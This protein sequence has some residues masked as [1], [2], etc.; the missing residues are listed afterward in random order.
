MAQLDDKYKTSKKNTCIAT[1]KHIWRE[2][3]LL[4]RSQEC[5]ESKFRVSLERSLNAYHA[6][7]GNENVGNLI[8]DQAWEGI[9][10]L[11]GVL[12]EEM[13]DISKMT[14]G[15]NNADI[16]HK[17]H[18]ELKDM[19]S[20]FLNESQESAFR[21][22]QSISELTK[23]NIEINIELLA[24]PWIRISESEI[25]N[26]KDLRFVDDELQEHHE[27]EIETLLAGHKDRKQQLNQ[28]YQDI[29]Q[30]PFGGWSDIDH[31][32]FR[33]LHD[34]YIGNEKHLLYRLRLEL[35]HHN[36]LSLSVCSS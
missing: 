36:S 22:Q 16:I 34:E 28:Q 7:S 20:N 15:G 5:Q 19:H 13:T 6:N 11:N 26:F 21:L 10:I 27:V 31:R 9:S 1:H 33:K 12:L 35:P 4:L 23:S 30:K 8:E 18:L 14:W 2:Y 24:M 17:R 32:I 29:T 25:R 3:D